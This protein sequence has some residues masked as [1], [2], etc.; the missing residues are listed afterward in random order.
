MYKVEEDLL[1]PVNV[2]RNVA[3]ESVQTHYVF[4]SDIELYPSPNIIPSFLKLIAENKGPLLS[5]NPKVFPLSIFEVAADQTVPNNK[6]VLAQMLRNGSAILFHKHLC[7][8]CHN[9]PKSKQWLDANE[10]KGLN[11]FH[12]GKRIASFMHWEP[13]YIGTNN[14]PLYDERL[15]WEGKSDKMTQVIQI[16][17]F[18]N[19]QF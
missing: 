2:G 16:V 12:V 10:T 9:V 13:I 11:V 14:D 8:D 18:V 19:I 6:T 5:K 7:P 3:R 4:P 15:S 17:N 1:Y